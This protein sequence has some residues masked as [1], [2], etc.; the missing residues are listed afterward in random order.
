MRYSTSLKLLLG[1]PVSPFLAFGNSLVKKSVQIYLAP[2][3]KNHQSVTVGLTWDFRQKQNADETNVTSFAVRAGEMLRQHFFDFN[4]LSTQR[5]RMRGREDVWNVCFT[6]T[7]PLKRHR[8]SIP[9]AQLT[10]SRATFSFVPIL[11]L[12]SSNPRFQFRRLHFSDSA[13]APL[14]QRSKALYVPNNIDWGQ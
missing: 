13:L 6:H 12:H 2:G 9:N 7:S 4:K 11:F 8:H 10:P 14:S 5:A 1:S 3:K